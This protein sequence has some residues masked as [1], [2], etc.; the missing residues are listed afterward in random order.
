MVAF[1]GP[2]PILKVKLGPLKLKGIIYFTPKSSISASPLRSAPYRIPKP[3]IL[4]CYPGLH[5]ISRTSYGLRDHYRRSIPGIQP[6]GILYSLVFRT[7]LVSHFPSWSFL[8]Y[9]YLRIKEAYQSLFQTTLSAGELSFLSYADSL[10]FTF[11]PTLEKRV[12]Q[13]T[14]SISRISRFV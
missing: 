3:E 1:Q 6:K 2:I 8:P 14:H 13:I 10:T 11:L 4:F 5:T 12:S 7:I 9:P